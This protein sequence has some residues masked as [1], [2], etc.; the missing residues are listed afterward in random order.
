[1]Q[2]LDNKQVIVIGLGA[3]GEAAVRLLLSE[4]A[5]V[6]A[7]DS[8]D[9]AELRKRAEELR[10]LG[11][12][13]QLGVAALDRADFALGIVSPG[14]PADSPLIKPLEEA[15]V[16]LLSEFELGWQRALCLSIGITGTNG[17]TTTTELVARLLTE[18]QRKTIAA[19]NIGLPV[20]DVV[21]Q[22]RS[23]DFLTLE[24]SSFQLERTQFIRPAIAVLLNLTP[25]HLDRYPTMT[26]YALAKARIFANQQSFDWAIVQ[27]EALAMLLS[28]GVKVPAK[29][30]TFS[31]VNQRAD[32]YYDRG[33]LISRLPGWEG[34]LIDLSKTKLCGPHNA[35]NLLAAF[36]VGR[37]LRMPLESMCT[38]LST[39]EPAPHRCELV[40]EIDGVKFVNDSKATNV[41]AVAKAIQAMPVGERGEPN[42]WLIAGGRDKGFDYYDIGPL[43]SRRVK[44]AHLIGETRDKLRSA[45][46]LFTPCVSHETLEEA[47]TGAA[48]AAVSGDIVLFSPA[49]ASFDMFRDYRHR[50]EMFR[51]AVKKR[52]VNTTGGADAGQ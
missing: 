26:D 50:G 4:R 25:D 47:V 6:T 42:L 22:S 2:K 14:V 35:E 12:D 32:L 15:G 11:A 33:L 21:A 8:A 3:S 1:M 43:L 13:V 17:K 20:C 34:V 52:A 45:W 40:A 9:S 28:L 38:A 27:S 49:C 51:K 7:V 16:Q 31:A 48:R 24:V 18:H 37:V 10:K 29:R 30:I 44:A 5:K 41:D 46:G 36:A 23:L 19:G 39:Y